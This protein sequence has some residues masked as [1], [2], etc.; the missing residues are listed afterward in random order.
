MPPSKESALKYTVKQLADLAG[1]SRRTLHYYDEIGLLQPSAVGENGYRYYGE[2]AVF[3][4]QQ[5]LF[6]RELDFS[7]DD[8]RAI[9]DSPDFD[10]LDSLQ[11]HKRELQKKVRRLTDL[12]H[13]IDRTL[14]HMKG[15]AEMSAQELFEGF[16]EETQKSYEKEA[17][18]RWGEGPVKESRRRWDSYTAQQKSR[19]KTE[20]EAIYRDL[21]TYVGQDPASEA[22]QHIIA[23]WH[24]HIRYFYEP[25]T[26]TLL[27]LGQMYVED[28]AFAAVYEKLHPD[29]PRFLQQAIEHYCRMITESV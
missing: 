11:A 24:Q 27:G 7:L 14:S 13:T 8:I 9:L 18:R 10:T 2:E 19:I 17:A 12:I 23:R 28:P 6:F 25:T 21:L 15:Q 20:G 5:I 22:V 29:M 26:D 4:L 16:D 3:R 1:V